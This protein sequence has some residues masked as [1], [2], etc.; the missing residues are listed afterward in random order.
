MNNPQDIRE[1]LMRGLSNKQIAHELHIGESTVTTHLRRAMKDY[2][3]TNRTA[4]ALRI[5]GV[6]HEAPQKQV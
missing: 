3:V 6:T 1:E 4:L 2:G 5:A